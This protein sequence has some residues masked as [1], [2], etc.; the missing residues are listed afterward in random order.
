MAKRGRDRETRKRVNLIIFL[1][2]LVFGAY[3]I[4]QPFA[5]LEIPEIVSKFDMWIIFA[6]G[7]LMIFGA[8][9]YYQAKS[10]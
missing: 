7:I 8:A 1:A 5:F 6:G 3:F 4:N 2:Y 9:Y 10:R